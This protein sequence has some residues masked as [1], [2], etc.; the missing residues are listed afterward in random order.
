MA[1]GKREAGKREAGQPGEAAGGKPAG[2]GGRH[3]PSLGKPGRQRWGWRPG[4]RG[5]EGGSDGTLRREARPCC[6]AGSLRPSPD[7][8]A[9]LSLAASGILAVFR[10]LSLAPP[11]WG[12]AARAGGFAAEQEIGVKRGRQL[13]LWKRQHMLGD[14]PHPCLHSPHGNALGMAEP[15]AATLEQTGAQRGD[16]PPEMGEAFSPAM[17]QARALQLSCLLRVQVIAGRKKHHQP[18]RKAWVGR[19]YLVPA[20]LPWA[21][22][23]PARSGCS[24]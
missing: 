19:D 10:D 6:R 2:C 24:P 11:A 15:P 17:L 21:G 8:E 18:H 16:L 4:C 20:P 22:M 1:A 12:H 23:P 5:A 9:G 14:H 3:G 13:G 7:G